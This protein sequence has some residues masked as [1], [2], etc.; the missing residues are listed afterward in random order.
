MQPNGYC[1]TFSDGTSVT[2]SDVAQARDW[3]MGQL[4]MLKAAL[5]A[6][7]IWKLREETGSIRPQDAI[8]KALA[9]EITATTALLN[10]GN[11]GDVI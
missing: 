2:F 6:L 8:G 9:I 3:V 5:P 10:F 1:I 4:Q 7:L 11:A